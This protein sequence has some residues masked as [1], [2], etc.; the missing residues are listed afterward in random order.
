MG[1]RGGKSEA[2]PWSPASSGDRDDLAAGIAVVIVVSAASV[3]FF[4]RSVAKGVESIH[5][6]T[7]PLVGSDNSSVT[8]HFVVV[9]TWP[10]AVLAECLAEC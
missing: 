5:A 6:H 10:S 7:S 2:G 4:T 8:D 3:L 1:N 9:K